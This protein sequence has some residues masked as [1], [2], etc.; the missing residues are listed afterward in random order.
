MNWKPVAGALLL[1][2]LAGAALTYWG[3][4]RPA[5]DPPGTVQRDSTTLGWDEL[6]ADLPRTTTVSAPDSSRRECME[7]PETIVDAA[8][9]PPDT[10]YHRLYA[11]IE[12]EAPS[13]SFGERA[14]LDVRARS[15]YPFL[16]LP[17]LSGGTPAIEH[18]GRRTTVRAYGPRR[19]YTFTYTYEPPNFELWAEG[20]AAAAWSPPTAPTRVNLHVGARL[21]AT[22]RRGAWRIE[23]SV[24]GA[25]TPIGPAATGGLAVRGVW[26]PLP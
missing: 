20:Y 12:S 6:V 25:L 11:E 2:L 24:G 7:V 23:P 4:P 14:G 18:T 9:P 15:R 19:G 1:G 26:T 13:V 3:V 17:L 10:V 8:R 22:I 5:D 21:G 16:Y